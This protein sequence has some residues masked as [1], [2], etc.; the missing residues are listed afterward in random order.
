MTNPELVPQKP[1]FVVLDSNVWIKELALQSIKA[2]AVRYF[3]KTRKAKLVV[4]EV[5]RLEV[6]ENIRQKM[7]DCRQAIQ[8]A[9]REL[10]QLIGTQREVS[11]PTDEEIDAAISVL[12][13]RTGVDVVDLPLTLAH[14]RSSF[15]KIRL[16]QPPS[17]NKQQFADGV[18]WAHCLD[19]LDEGDVYFVANDKAFFKGNDSKTDNL[20]PNL[21]RE[22]SERENDLSLYAN[23]EGLMKDIRVDVTLD[24]DDLISEVRR[25]GSTEILSLLED[26]HF[27]LGSVEILD[28]RAFITEAPNQLYVQVAVCWQPL[29]DE[30]LDG[31]VD[32]SLT[33]V[34]EGKFLT[35]GKFSDGRLESVSINYTGESGTQISRKTH[36]LS[37]STS[38]GEAA[39]VR[40]ELR[41]N[42]EEI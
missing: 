27:S 13:D 35:T 29:F 20:A 34:A 12:I 30:A 31:R 37:A 8:R 15:A 22:A 10:L 26:H 40:H 4:P 24:H 9:H 33:V 23:L 39:T 19:L 38:L 21:C 16:K 1:L 41:V 36:Y 25:L 32:G 5:V 18:I 7:I 6:E 28:C 2:S 3:L 11:L 14:V 42:A 17:H